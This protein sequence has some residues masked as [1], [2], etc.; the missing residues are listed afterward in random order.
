M[1]T[2]AVRLI[3]VLLILLDIAGVAALVWLLPQTAYCW[4]LSSG[5]MPFPFSMATYKLDMR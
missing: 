4:A 2:L 3:R 5:F 1:L